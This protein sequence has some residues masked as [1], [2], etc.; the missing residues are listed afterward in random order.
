MLYSMKGYKIQEALFL[1]SV[2]VVVYES[3]CRKI[4]K[5]NFN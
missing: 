3:E 1:I 5:H 4:N 2:Y